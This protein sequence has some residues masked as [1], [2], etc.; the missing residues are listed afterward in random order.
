[1]A[2][3]ER[4]TDRYLPWDVRAQKGAST[5]SPQ[6]QP[7]QPDSRPLVRFLL[8]IYGQVGPGHGLWRMGVD[9]SAELWVTRF[10]G[11]RSATAQQAS[12]NLLV[13]LQHGRCQPE[14]QERRERGV[15]TVAVTAAA[16]RAWGE[17][18]RRNFGRAENLDWPKFSAG[19]LRPSEESQ[20]HAEI[21][22]QPNKSEGRPWGPGE[23]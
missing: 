16:A 5:D 13:S 1:M 6:N 11:A 10:P 18:P 8:K 20:P 19:R 9:A 7:A 12:L 22:G 14:P 4:C 2:E 3:R 23:S 15:G 17:W 21:F